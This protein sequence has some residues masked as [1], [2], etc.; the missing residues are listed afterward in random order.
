MVEQ[1]ADDFAR[2]RSI[3]VGAAAGISRCRGHASTE[4]VANQAD[5]RAGFGRFPVRK[6]ARAAAHTSWPQ[7]LRVEGWA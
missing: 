7:N 5:A 6:I 1:D 2:A 4:P 3:A